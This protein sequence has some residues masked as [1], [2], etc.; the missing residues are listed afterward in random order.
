VP[1]IAAPHQLDVQHA[2][3]Q[4]SAIDVGDFQFAARRRPDLCGDIN[5]LVVVE[6]QAGHG[7]VGLRWSALSKINT[8]CYQS[9]FI[10]NGSL[11]VTHPLWLIRRTMLRIIECRIGRHDKHITIISDDPGLAIEAAR[12]HPDAIVKSFTANAKL[13]QKQCGEPPLTY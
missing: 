9:L 8:A 11:L 2:A 12:G 4:I 7:V 3:F 6:I 5:H 1:G 13:D 10:R